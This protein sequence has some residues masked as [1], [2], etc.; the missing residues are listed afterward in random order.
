MVECGYGEGDVRLLWIVADAVAV[1]R[2][3][4]K[5]QRNLVF[6][7]HL[8][9]YDNYK[10]KYLKLD[11]SEKCKCQPGSSTFESGTCV[12]GADC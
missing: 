1:G 9:R 11:N 3:R 8:G 7:G 12:E 4:S 10:K 5:C 2:G 6:S